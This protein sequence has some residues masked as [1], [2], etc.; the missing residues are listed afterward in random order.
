M[1]IRLR[2]GLWYSGLAAATI[3]IF[4][5][6]VYSLLA[7]HQLGEEQE[8]VLLRAQQLQA[9]MQA[10]AHLPLHSRDRVLLYINAI[11]SPGIYVQLV[12]LNG[13]IVARSDNLGDQ[14]LAVDM[15]NLEAARS[16]RAALS[17]SR[18]GQDNVSVSVRPL[19]VD[20]QIVGFVAVGT[21]YFE[22]LDSLADLR[23]VLFGAG[24][25]LT[26]VAGLAGW[27]IAG[28]TFRSI[29]LIT[30]GA[31]AITRSPRYSGFLEE[32]NSGDEVGRL[33]HTI[34]QM[35]TSLKE[36]YTAQQCFIADASHELRMPLSAIRAYL[37]LLSR[38]GDSLPVEERRKVVEAGTDEADRMARL[39]DRLLVLVRAD[40]GQ[41][42]LRP[43]ELDRLV[44]EVY[45]E[46]K[47]LAKGRKIGLKQIDQVTVMG[48]P[49]LLKELVFILVDNAI[50]YTPPGHNIDLAL[51]QDGTMALLSVR[52]SGMGIPPEDLPHIFGR[53]YRG[54]AARLTPGSGLGLAIARCIIEQHGGEIVVE[55]TPGAGSTFTVQ[56]PLT[57]SQHAALG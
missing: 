27:M 21:T 35:L 55:S 1:S 37:E 8:E 39:I 19:S 2:L 51:H 22:V 56:L 54:K 17:L 7:R 42:N 40:A 5:L 18:V 36:A 12:D 26:A 34:N 3:V 29:E 53:F 49:D 25:L 31:E 30:R 47:V 57:F 45:K 44:M 33:T 6:L 16:G 4:S 41:L 50:K 23:L 10:D 32:G 14:M 43:T 38:H 11:A 48:D 28:G 13:N 46:A 20:Q 52:D 15:R 9:V 24:L